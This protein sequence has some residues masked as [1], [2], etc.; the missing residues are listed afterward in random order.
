VLVLIFTMPRCLAL[1]LASC[2]AAS[3]HASLPCIM[4]RIM[5]RCLALCL[6]AS[7]CIV[8]L[9]FNPS[10]HESNIHCFQ[11]TGLINSLT[12]K[13]LQC[14]YLP[15]SEQYGEYV[16]EFKSFHQRQYLRNSCMKKSGLFNQILL[17]YD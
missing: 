4:P 1:C 11:G 7:H 2:L 5:P 10:K 15:T 14:F 16:I 6:A 8:K 12:C 13:L 3:H 9:I 17:I